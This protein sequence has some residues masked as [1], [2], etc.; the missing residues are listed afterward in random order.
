MDKRYKGEWLTRSDIPN[1]KERLEAHLEFERS[2]LKHKL[3]DGWRVCSTRV[4]PK[5]PRIQKPVF[6][7]FG[8]VSLDIP[9]EILIK[10]G[11]R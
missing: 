11:F 9:V 5:R 3:D 7:M 1:R 6:R 8:T 2:E 4:R 10:A